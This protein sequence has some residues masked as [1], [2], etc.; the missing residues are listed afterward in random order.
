MVGW[1]RPV[2]GV[3]AG[4][5]TAVGS[6]RLWR[7][8]PSP[9]RADGA[10]DDELEYQQRQPKDER[11]ADVARE[12]M[13]AAIGAFKEYIGLAPPEDVRRAGGVA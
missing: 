6:G 10:A 7:L 5:V 9:A 4:V 12:Y 2:A 3:V 1:R 11:D 8:R 13:A